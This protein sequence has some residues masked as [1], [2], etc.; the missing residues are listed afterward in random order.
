MQARHG[1]TV[2]KSMLEKMTDANISPEQMINMA[3]LG[4]N[5][6]GSQF[7]TSGK[8]IFTARGFEKAGLGSMEQNMQ[9]MGSLA[10]AGSNNPQGNLESVMAAA[11]TK[12]L[13]GSKALD[14]MV[15]NTAELV[16]QTDAAAAGIDTTAVSAAALAAST[17]PDMKN[18]EYAAQRAMTI[19]QIA[20]SADT[21][22]STTFSGFVNTARISKETGL[23]GIDAIT[24]GETTA[25]EWKALQ[26]D[27]DAAKKLR[28]M[29]MSVKDGDAQGVINK[30]I[31]LKQRQVAEGAGAANALGGLSDSLFEKLKGDNLVDTDPEFDQAAKIARRSGYKTVQEYQNAVRSGDANVV[32]T[33]ELNKKVKDA[34]DPK[35]MLKQIDDLRTGGFK[36]L[37][38]AAGSAAT[39]LNGIGGAL[40]V[41]TEL[42]EK[43]KKGGAETEKE[44]STAGGKA[45]DKFVLGADRFGDQVTRL[46]G[47][48]N[49]VIGK[50]GMYVP[51]PSDSKTEKAGSAR[52]AG[53][54]Q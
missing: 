44:M 14:L 10:A 17:D 35:N 5:A 6:L 4:V 30:M 51:E 21:N 11:M 43:Y 45:A 9:R 50:S 25:G 31:N 47:I 15:S 37:S 28:A 22:V 2:D 29:G 23:S 39:A 12:G 53:A 48:L 18:R 36:Q 3:Q 54:P 26:S 52:N 27:P 34:D 41:F 19:Q 13:D 38:E 16:K 20:R 8:Q 1:D 46:E 7:D 40:K 24:A 33:D 32:P 42:N 49:N